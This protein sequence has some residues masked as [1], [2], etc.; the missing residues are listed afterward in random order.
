MSRNNAFRRAT[1]AI[2]QTRS[3][4]LEAEGSN[5]ATKSRDWREKITLLT[6]SRQKRII[7]IESVFKLYI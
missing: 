7:V 3:I 1:R 2:S 4:K 6:Y 5:Y